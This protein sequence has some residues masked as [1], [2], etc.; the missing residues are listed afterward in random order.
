MITLIQNTAALWASGNPIPV[1]NSINIETDSI[2]GKIGD[3]VT[4]YNDLVYWNA[5]DGVIAILL[6]LYP[7]LSTTASP[8][9]GAAGGDLTGTYPNP[10]LS[11]VISASTKGSVL[12][13]LTVTYDAKGRLTSVTEN[14]LPTSFPPNGSAGGDLTGS[15]PNPTLA[16]IISAS[17]KG[18]ASKSLT[19]VYDA[20]GR[21]TTVTENN[22]LIT[23]SQVT[24]LTTDLAGL[25]AG[26]ATKEPLLCYDEDW[27]VFSQ[28]ET[29]E[30]ND[31]TYD[32][33][34]DG[35]RLV[36]DRFTRIDSGS[37]ELRFTSDVAELDDM[38]KVGI[39][40][41][42]CMAADGTS[43]RNMYACMQS[44]STKIINIIATDSD[45]ARI[46]DVKNCSLVIKVKRSG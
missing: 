10:T 20:K 15:Y 45:G 36:V 19:L 26:L 41:H 28:A 44:G 43:V 39:Q 6:Y 22:I 5:G 40:I 14:T 29:E 42:N 16:G 18:S 12:K 34:C 35:L 38:N 23:E 4:H 25:A 7:L 3:G 17:T 24:N 32:I 37:Y 46:D 30:G 21:L 11:A 8:P 31:P 13:T 9:S 1:V 2:K 27:I 33:D